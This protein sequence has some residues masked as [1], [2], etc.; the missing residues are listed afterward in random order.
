MSQPS[1][2]IRQMRIALKEVHQAATRGWRLLPVAA[3]GKKPLIKQWQRVATGDIFQLESWAK[4]FPGCNWGLATGPG[5]GVF[6]IDLDGDTGLDWLRERIDA[7]NEVPETWSIRTARGR[8]LYFAY[9]A[10]LDIRNSVS[11]LANGVD[12][13]G[14]GGYV[15]IPPSVHPE[16]ARYATVDESCPVSPVP[17]WLLDLLRKLAMESGRPRPSVP[18]FE[19]IPAGRRNDTLTRKGGYLRRKGLDLAEI[20][21]V[22]LQDN[23]RK[24]S[25]PL[26]DAEVSRIAASVARYPVGGPDPL[27]A[28]WNVVSALG[29]VSGYSG[30]IALAQALQEARPGLPVALPLERIA[31]LFGVHFTSVQQWRKK[32]LSCG[33]LKQVGQYIAHRKAGTFRVLISDSI[34]TETLTKPLTTLTTGLVRDHENPIVRT[35]VLPIVRVQALPDISFD[36]GHNAYCET[37]LLRR[38]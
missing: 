17:P 30:F 15:L 5:S 27:E 20:E 4:Q 32:A 21:T 12:V 11:K 35:E 24:C 36:F 1:S 28:A 31:E 13:R 19:I 9:P 23:Q 34:Q 37:R 2:T 29:T 18:V 14:A 33:D 6:V 38:P 10:G 7:G 8:H 16:G 22:L 3:R 25:P 26:P